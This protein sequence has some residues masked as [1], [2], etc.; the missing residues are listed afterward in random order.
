M[1]DPQRR[2]GGTLDLD[3]R[4]VL[5]GIDRLP[6]CPCR[7]AV[8][9]DTHLEPAEQQVTRGDF[10][11]QGVQPVDQQQLVVSRLAAQLDGRERSDP[12]GIG[13][14]R[15]HCQRRLLERLVTGRTD[16]ANADVRIVRK[17][18]PMPGDH[19]AGPGRKRPSGHVAYR[20]L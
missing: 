20:K 5:R 18:L 2:V 4:V 11:D 3:R 8:I 6:P 9:D 15:D 19:S 1:P 10:E 17:V 12:C 14:H 16:A 7:E 13:H